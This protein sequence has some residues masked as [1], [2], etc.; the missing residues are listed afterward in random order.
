LV[1]DQL[2]DSRKDKDIAVIHFYCDYREQQA[3]T[4]ANCARNM[5]RQL[6]MQC[7]TVP[8]S[9]AEFYQRTRSE[10]K[11]QSWYAELRQ[12]VCRVA[13]TFSKCYFVIDAL[14]EAEVESHMSGLLELL[15]ILRSSVAT[16]AK[17]F[18]TSRKHTSAIQESF[19]DA[20]K[21]SVTANN[22]DL[23]T[24]LAKIIADQQRSKYILDDNL[25]EDILV[26]LCAGAHGMYV[27][28]PQ[29]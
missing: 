26:T 14:D 27:L 25:K 28:P 29:L 1:V 12:I 5:L 13:S 2:L 15:G 23:R 22:E 9:V 3:Q 4:P 24:I 16:T 7:N 18:A 19:Q 6:S 8:T 10:V 21:V 11:E 17:I 20:T